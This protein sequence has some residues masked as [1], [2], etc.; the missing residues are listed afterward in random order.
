MY[1]AWSCRLASSRKNGNPYCRY[2]LASRMCG[3]LSDVVLACCL[4]ELTPSGFPPPIETTQDSNASAE[5]PHANRY[6]RMY[7]YIYE[8][9]TSKYIYTWNVIYTVQ[10]EMH[11]STIFSCWY[12]IDA[13]LLLHGRAG[14]L[15]TKRDGQQ[16]TRNMVENRF[17]FREDKARNGCGGERL[18]FWVHRGSRVLTAPRKAVGVTAHSPRVSCR[19]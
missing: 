9:Y 16:Y 8:V 10:Q 6:T 1:S 14:L 4:C 2:M 7:I 19:G 17:S 11:I 18:G 13:A 5:R 3:L 12:L 15:C